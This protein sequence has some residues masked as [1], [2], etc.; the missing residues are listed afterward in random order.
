MASAA[1]SPRALT[2]SAFWANIAAG[3]DSTTEVPVDRWA[4]DP[5]VAFDPAVATPDHV[6]ATRGGFVGPV[7]V[8]LTG[9]D[10]D[11]FID[12]TRLDPAFHLALYAGSRAWRDAKT[13]EVDRA[14]VGVVFGNIVLP[15]VSTSALAEDT[16]GRAF[17]RQ[18]LGAEPSART[19]T[20]PLNRH[21]AGLPAGLLARALGLGG[22]AYTLDAACASTLYALKL[23]A[24]EVLSGRADAMLTGG[25]S[26]PDPLYTQMGF[27]QLRALSPDG[28][29]Y[30]FDARG[31]GLVVGEGAGMFV[32]KRLSDA[33]RHGDTIYGLVAA[34]GLSND[35][36]G[37]LLAP[38]GEGQLRALR[39][40]YE[41]AGWEPERRRPDRM[42]RDR[43]ARRR[44]R[45]IPEPQNVVERR[46]LG[47]PAVAS[48]APTKPTSATCSRLPAH[49]A[50]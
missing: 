21:A 29:A 9:L 32:V 16:L 47:V 6:Y 44:R 50:C 8:D 45:R 22:G 46:R 11:S 42:P 27:S 33:L 1:S 12:L 13:V 23:A 41:Q 7:S 36:D 39:A 49:Q 14:R 2:L 28:R 38:S 10:I 37:G 35:V 25:L 31:G 19:P 43:H 40:A 26:R 5:A 4:L 20:D 15:T 3:I 48:S 24:D 30:P 34:V 18:V 17:E